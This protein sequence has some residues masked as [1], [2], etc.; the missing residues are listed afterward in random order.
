MNGV[1]RYR[2]VRKA[3]DLLTQENR[4][5]LT[6]S[7]RLEILE[8]GDALPKFFRSSGCVWDF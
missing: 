7:L 5:M 4:T 2:T 6:R 8:K 3:G 1:V